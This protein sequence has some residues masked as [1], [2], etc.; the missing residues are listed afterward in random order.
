[1]TEDVSA[2]SSGEFSPI[3]L[4]RDLRDGSLSPATLTRDGRLACVEHLTI[5]GYSVGE[6]AEVLKCSTRTIHRDRNQIRASNAV[7]RDP[8]LLDNMVGQLVQ[9]ADQS[10]QKLIRV[11]RESGCPQAVQVD[12][13]K[14]SWAI[15]RELVETLQRLGH[16]PT[17]AQEIKA[18]LTLEVPGFDSMQ[19]EV[20]RI[21][22]VMEQ[23]G[24]GDSGIREQLTKLKTTVGQLSVSEQ[25]DQIRDRIESKEGE[26]V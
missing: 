15:R 12:A 13:H 24:G 21:E 25:I 19:K 17:V 16:L 2:A 6:I 3:K 11:S 7:G 4:L 14:A 18:D 10:V 5:E 1:M 9:H 23:S 20:N 8:K 26:D 22:L